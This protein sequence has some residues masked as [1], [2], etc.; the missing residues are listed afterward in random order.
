MTERVLWV[1]D[2]EPPSSAA[3]EAGL[4]EAL[5]GEAGRHLIGP[6]AFKSDVAESSASMPACIIGLEPC[7]SVYGLAFSN[8]NLALVIR[9]QWEGGQR[10]GSAAS[11]IKANYAVVDRRGELIR[12]GSVVGPNEREVAFD[13]VR[14]I[15]D[16]TGLVA[17]EISPAG[18]RVEIGEQS[19]GEA[20][21]GKRLAVGA[22]VYRIVLEGYRPVEGRVEIGS[23]SSVLIRHDLSL[24][25]GTLIIEGAPAGATLYINEVARGPASEPAELEPGHY[26]IEVRAEGY[27][28][29][30]ETVRISP[31]S[32][33]ALMAVLEGSSSFLGAVSRQAI[34]SHRFG[35]R[36]GYES[37][38]HSTTF[39]SARHRSEGREYEFHG[40]SADGYVPDDEVLRRFVAPHGLRL[41]AYVSGEYFGLKLLSLSWL[42]TSLSLPA[43]VEIRETRERVD[44]DVVGLNRLQ[45]RPFQLTV[46]TFYEGLVP[47][48]DAGTGISFQRLTVEG[49]GAREEG[50]RGEMSLRQTE[51][52][53][54]VGAGVQYF[55]S[56]RYALM[57][58]YGVQGYFNEGLGLEH[59]LGVSIGMGFQNV[60]GFEAEP[61]GRL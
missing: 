52:F 45:V 21:V 33:S 15:F 29:F 5:A 60:F 24:L 38:L 13:L 16:A 46:R 14:E 39:R 56:P 57:A 3:F 55:L 40:F 17:F 59:T 49:V 53:W 12:E 1:W 42:R 37:S 44:V 22:H 36:L 18:A 26:S 27:E 41:E 8:L 32:Q 35:L 30:R 20:P 51:A 2:G 48:V 31:G 19:I 9:L 61:P 58:R 6:R 28:T 11:E 50:E 47:Q 4:T 43:Q 34:Q 25:P 54:S 10:E 23:A 7:V